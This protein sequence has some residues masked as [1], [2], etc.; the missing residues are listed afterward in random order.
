MTTAW[1][2]G[3]AIYLRPNTNIIINNSEFSNC[4]SLREAGALY[5]DSNTATDIK[6]LNSKFI[7]NAAKGQK[8]REGDNDKGGG[9]VMIKGT[10]NVWLINDTFTGNTANFGGALTVWKLNAN[11]VN[12]INSTFDGNKATGGDEG[13]NKGGSIYA[14]STFNL[15]NVTIRNSEAE[16][17]GGAY[18]DGT[19]VVCKNITFIDNTATN[20]GG[21][22]YWAKNNAVV[23]DMVFLNNTAVNNGGALYVT[24]TGV[25]VTDVNMTGN[26]AFSGSAI[27]SVNA[28]T[29]TNVYLIENQANSSSLELITYDETTGDV[30][31]LFKGNDK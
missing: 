13:S 20:N 21:G 10:K 15:V 6:V 12:I 5:I 4:W 16:N 27:Y 1:I 22:L 11:S 26:K 18:F 8:A 17:G 9:A 3:G 25:R 7:N 23:K 2:Q 28:I 19:D 14:L 31:L 30:V 24:N 29:L